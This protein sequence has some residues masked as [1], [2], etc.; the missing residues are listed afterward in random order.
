MSGFSVAI[1]GADGEY[2]AVVVSAANRTL[3]PEGFVFPKGASILVLQNEVPEAVNRAVAAEARDNDATV[4]LNAAP[5]RPTAPELMRMV[6]LL[7]VNRIEAGELFGTPIHTARD[8]L[9]AAERA[10]AG[11]TGEVILTLGGDGLVHRDLGGGVRHHAV[12]RVPVVS[13][14]GAGDVFVGALCARMA[15]GAAME[16]AIACAQEPPPPG[17]CRLRSGTGGFRLRRVARFP[18][19]IRGAD[20]TTLSAIP[21]SII[22]DNV[23][24]NRRFTI[25][26][27]GAPYARP[28]AVVPTECRPMPRIRAC[29]ALTGLPQLESEQRR[30]VGTEGIG[31]PVGRISAMLSTGCPVLNRDLAVSFALVPHSV[32]MAAGAVGERCRFAAV[33]GAPRSHGRSMTK[34]AGKAATEPSI[35]SGERYPM[36]AL[37][38]TWD[39]PRNDRRHGGRSGAGAGMRSASGMRRRYTTRWIISGSSPPGSR[40]R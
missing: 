3:S 16:D 29:G 23:G 34:S 25:G 33:R 17:S 20:R 22:R 18:V 27:P 36:K 13:A 12:R 7:I 10:A 21:T 8:A 4:V 5:M 32:T 38:K 2:G 30:P 37:R 15:A 14:H 40:R 28:A 11:V 9:D 19:L 35:Q 39:R 24:A 26:I 1:V 31:T 6:D